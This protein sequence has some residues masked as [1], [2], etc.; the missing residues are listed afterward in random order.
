MYIISIHGY[1]HILT[2]NPYNHKKGTALGRPRCSSTAEGDSLPMIRSK[3]QWQLSLVITCTPKVRKRMAQ[4]P[5]REPS[6]PLIY[7]GIQVVSSRSGDQEVIGHACHPVGRLRI[8]ISNFTYKGPSSLW[9]FK[10]RL[11][12]QRAAGRLTRPQP[13]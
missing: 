7:L 11:Q 3:D 10:S 5:Q 12:N 13:C 8:R 1:I 9:P 4:G 6:K 2:S